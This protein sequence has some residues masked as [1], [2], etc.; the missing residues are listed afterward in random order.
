MSGDTTAFLAGCAITG[1][2]AVLLLRG[3]FVSEQSRMQS[4]QPPP[5]TSLQQVPP[6]SLSAPGVTQTSEQQWQLERELEQ[7]RTLTTELKNQLEQQKSETDDLKTAIAQQKSDTERLMTQLQQRV[8][9]QQRLL[10]AIAVEQQISAADQ[11]RSS[12]SQLSLAEQLRLSNPPE[13]PIRLQN[14]LLWVVGVTLI[15]LALGGG[16]ILVIL[17]VLLVQSQ[18]RYPRSM[19]VIHPMPSPYVL[20]EQAL[21]PSQTRAPRRTSQI[22]IYED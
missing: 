20:P 17:I 15:I 14:T 19:H 9:T 7:Q 2:A 10:D 21:L 13:Q 3:G 16:I 18:R 12:A 11:S 5:A 6:S 1:V 8:E 22:E 4:I